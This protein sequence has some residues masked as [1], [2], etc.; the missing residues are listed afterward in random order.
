MRIS[1]KISCI[2]IF[3][4]LRFRAFSLLEIAISLTII[5][6]AFAGILPFWKLLLFSRNQ[7]INELKAVQVRYAIQGFVLRYGFL[8]YAAKDQNGIETHGNH[9]GFLPYKTLG[10]SKNYIMDSHNKPFTFIM[11][12]HLGKNNEK[13]HLP[14]VIPFSIELPKDSCTFCRIYEFDKDGRVCL[15]DKICHVQNIELVAK[16]KDVFDSEHKKIY[17]MR[18]ISKYLSNTIAWIK[19]SLTEDKKYENCDCVA[20]I[21]ISHGQ[22]KNG[23]KNKCREMNRCSD[24]KFCLEP[25]PGDTGIFDDQIFWQSRFDLASQIGTPCSTEAIDEGEFAKVQK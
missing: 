20:W 8:P 18:P 22:S 9:K 10:L 25:E 11:N 14:P 13:H 15:Y 1:K 24:S 17:I 7:R 23:M 5:G 2:N 6:I 12:K 21:L 19:L 3:R 4:K 16:G